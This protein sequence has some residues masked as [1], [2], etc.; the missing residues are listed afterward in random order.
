MV[1]TLLEFGADP[2]RFEP[3]PSDV[4]NLEY[5]AN[6]LI[7]ACS[8]D[9]YTRE[10]VEL[11]LENGADVNAC[12]EDPKTPLD[13]EAESTTP[14]FAALYRR[15]RREYGVERH[16]DALH[17]LLTREQ[18]TYGILDC[19]MIDRVDAVDILLRYG[20]D[21][22]NHTGMDGSLLVTAVRYDDGRL[23]TR[24]LEAGVEVNRKGHE[25]YPLEEAVRY[26]NHAC[27]KLLLKAGADPAHGWK[28]LLA[29][30]RS[31]DSRPE[32]C[33]SVTQARVDRILEWGHLL[34]AL[35]S[36]PDPVR[37]SQALSSYA[38]TGYP[39]LL[40]FMLPFVTEVN[41]RDGYAGTALYE[42]GR[43]LKWR[44]KISKPHYD[45]TEEDRRFGAM[46]NLLKEKG[47]L[48]LP[49]IGPGRSEDYTEIVSQLH[50]LSKED[51]KCEIG[52][53]TPWSLHNIAC[54]GCD[55]PDI[56]GIRFK[57]LNCGFADYCQ[58]CF[59]TI[60]H[61][62]CHDF[63]AVEH[64]LQL[65]HTLV[66]AKSML[67]LSKFRERPLLGDSKNLVIMQLGRPTDR[68][69]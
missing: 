9:W 61:E 39:E 57:C 68:C 8:N 20:A 3:N 7:L 5:S 32:L 22:G 63:I 38:W 50:T 65:R 24:L 54:C 52:I 36:R 56:V 69:G 64:P 62:D 13:H 49:P 4:V 60:E 43:E 19:D 12:L 67:R 51:A 33:P 16:I 27:A 6:P 30:F 15:P 10:M 11:L 45:P 31:D 29:L 48:I 21:A 1:T 41:Y 35:N 55:D 14:L 44:C 66:M 53:M 18:Q 23:T 42:V 25:F 58:I 2:N 46:V 26:C 34:L 47:A 37:V 59:S 40:F 28:A 17:T